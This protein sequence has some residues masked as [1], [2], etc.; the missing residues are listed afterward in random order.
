MTVRD[1]L[2]EV[3][4]G[5]VLALALTVAQPAAAAQGIWISAQELAQIP[6]TGK[7]WQAL[8]A[9]A[10]QATGT[11]DLSNQDDPTNVRVLAKGLAFARSGNHKFRNEVIEAI[12]AAMG[13]EA[14]GRT[15]ALGRELLAYVIA[16]DLVG[17]PAD[18]DQTFRAYLRDVRNKDLDG[19]TLIDT[20]EDRPNNWG[21]HAGATRLA[22]AVYLGDQADIERAAKVFK[23]YLG[24]RAAYAS[25]TYGDLA[26]QADPAKP[27]GLN[28]RGA[29]KNGH[30]LDG[31][32]PEEMR[33]SGG[34][35]WPPP[36]ENY[37]WEALQGAVAQG[38]IL[39]RLGYDVWNWQDRALLR[40]FLWLHQQ[41][42]FPAEGDDAW[43]THLFNFYYGLSYPADEGAGPGKNI[44]W[45]GWTHGPLARH[46]GSPPAAD[47][48]PPAAPILIE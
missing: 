39:H 14:G 12:N 1:W 17:L 22:I 41:A 29:T 36:K 18:V 8:I 11:P 25:F 6:M 30:P 5:L 9:E 35:V 10:N 4:R 48:T 46:G 20:H 28:L 16:A 32:L 7:G 2:R 43:Q 34:F 23:G 15:L 33:R 45:T 42:S 47:T 13:T 19:R 21:C 24:D 26:W 38:V 40:A 27:V 44:G 31:S 37:A 3:Q